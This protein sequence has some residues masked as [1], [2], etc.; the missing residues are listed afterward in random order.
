MYKKKEEKL[1]ALKF[2]FLDNED[3]KSMAHSLRAYNHWKRD[4]FWLHVPYSIFKN[5]A[6]IFS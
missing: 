5:T 3:I 6:L 1:L 4:Y 2:S